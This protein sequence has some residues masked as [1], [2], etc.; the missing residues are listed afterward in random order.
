MSDTVTFVTV[1]N[2]YTISV[3]KEFI[4]KCPEYNKTSIKDLLT[5]KKIVAYFHNTKGPAV[6]RHKDGHLEY[7]ING[8]VATK[9]EAEKI[10][11]NADF[12]DQLSSIVND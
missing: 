4:E 7:W 8:M 11:H 2:K 3:K 5:E 9:E 6:T 12:S 10:Q 1:D